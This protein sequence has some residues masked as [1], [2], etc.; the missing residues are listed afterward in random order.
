ML[1]NNIVQGVAYL[2]RAVAK[3]LIDK[4]INGAVQDLV[5]AFE[6][7]GLKQALDKVQ[8]QIVAAMVAAQLA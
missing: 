1:D 7:F 2:A 5:K 8:S 6:L 4:D 3:F